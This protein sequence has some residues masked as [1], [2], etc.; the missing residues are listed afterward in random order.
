LLDG[1]QFL[2]QLKQTNGVL[3]VFAFISAYIDEAIIQRMDSLGVDCIIKKPVD[4]E[5]LKIILLLLPLKR[6]YI[7]HG[8]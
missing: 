3:P 5:I 1:F 6:K 8:T 4:Q 2:Q 7:S